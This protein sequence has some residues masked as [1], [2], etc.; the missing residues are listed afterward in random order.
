[1]IFDTMPISNAHSRAQ[2][3]D[4]RHRMSFAKKVFVTFS[5]IL[6]IAPHT[7]LGQDTSVQA[8]LSKRVMAV[9]EEVRLTIRVT[10]PRGNLQA[11]RL[12]G[13]K[14]FDTFYTGRASHVTFVNG[15]STSSVEFSYVLIPRSAGN[16]T[17]DSVK[18]EVN[19]QN[20]QTDPLDVE[21]TNPSPG[22][23]P[24]TPTQQP[25]SSHQGGSSIPSQV[26]VQPPQANFVPTD[27][28][29][30]IRAVV[31]KTTVYPNEQI[32][33]SYSLYTRY[34]TRYEGFEEEPAVS[35]FWIEEFPPD[36]DVRRETV[37]LNGKRYVKADVKKV[38]LFP[39]A[40]ADYTIQ[41]GTI[42]VSI[43]HEPRNTS[44]FDEFFNDSFFT[45]GSFFSRREN[46]LLKP[47]PIEVK[48]IP[49]PE[50][51]KPSDFNGAVGNIRMSASVDKR[52]VVQ[53]EPVTMTLVLEGEGNIETLNKPNIPE[54]TAF[55]IYESDTSSE[56][57]KTGNV[58]GGKKTFEIVFIPTEAGNLNIPTLSFSFFNPA[59]GTYQTLT[60]DNFP[61]NVKPSDQPF[62]LPK[63]LTQQDVFKK[64]IEVEG[65]DIRYILEKAPDQSRFV[66]MHN[67]VLGL[68]FFNLLL[69]VLLGVGLYRERQERIFEKDHGLKRHRYARGQAEK[70]MKVIKKLVRSEKAE[71]VRN[72][73]EE[74]GKTITQYVSDKFNL[75]SY[76]VTE[77]E[78]ENTLKEKLKNDEA[79]AEDILKVYRQ[80]HEARFAGA[81]VSHEEKSHALSILR[82]T[83]SK[84]EK[85]KR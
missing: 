85:L 56:L 78:L 6:C 42:K 73:Y 48:V 59:I 75:S 8:S 38:A 61:L 84:L 57:F 13:F 74:V 28:N 14:N 34:D 81:N 25:I 16:F 46:R 44:I 22:Q 17:I 36:K 53:N 18:M 40:A 60:T 58:I 77:M 47:P 50:S 70:R 5:V 24:S 79:L 4:K 52:E 64:D 39:T 72:F 41:P 32:T 43:R 21:V 80:S 55:K 29:I 62:E 54:L 83:I 20:F 49:F 33:L 9:N 12:P 10:G 51:G 67:S 35:G 45:G 63:V 15:Q 26:P 66:I 71:D 11:P 65:R 27:D 37:R 31:D 68:M 69:T 1:M 19:G 23:V 7:L 76:G 3:G 30:F 82:K 2:I